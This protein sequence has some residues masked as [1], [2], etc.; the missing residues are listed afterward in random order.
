MRDQ[1]YERS[2]PPNTFRI[3]LLGP[4]N[5]MGWGVGD[6]ETFEALVEERLN[7]ERTERRHA[8]SRSSISVCRA[9][10]R[11]NNSSH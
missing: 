9:I 1:D 5:V 11:R 10:G 3:A 7:R 2:P 8:S 6:G 4:S